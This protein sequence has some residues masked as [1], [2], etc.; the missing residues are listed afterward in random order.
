MSKLDL[1]HLADL[2]RALAHILNSACREQRLVGAVVGVSHQGHACCLS[3]HGLSDRDAGS[4][5]L[6]TTGFRLASLTK[7]IVT[8]AALRLVAMGALDLSAPITRWM[9]WF[10]PTTAT[11]DTPV[12]TVHHLLSHTE[13]GRAHV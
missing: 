3:A 1:N 7:P 9:P 5:M 6:T 11:G 8:L 12:I 2:P 10:L 4:P 13:I